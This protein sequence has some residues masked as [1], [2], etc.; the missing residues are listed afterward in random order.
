MLLAFKIDGDALETACGNAQI[1]TITSCVLSL[2]IELWLV[3]KDQKVT[4]MAYFDCEV[5][6]VVRYCSA[7]N[8]AAMHKDL[9]WRF[10]ISDTIAKSCIQKEDRKGDVCSIID[11]RDLHE[12]AYPWSKSS[13]ANDFWKLP[14]MFDNIWRN[15]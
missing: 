11:F 15:I 5:P 13:L 12:P 4:R 8:I 3:K 10:Q 7:L 14:Q 1:K 9:V 2:L 6:W